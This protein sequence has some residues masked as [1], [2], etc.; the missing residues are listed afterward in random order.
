MAV[1]SLRYRPNAATPEE[2]KQG[3][4]VYSGSAVDYHH[5]CF[6]AEVKM[7]AAKDGSMLEVVSKIVEAL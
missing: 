5:W 7:K 3:F 6:R 2:T 1:A 4:I